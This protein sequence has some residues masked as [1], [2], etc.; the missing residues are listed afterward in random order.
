MKVHS[1]LL[2]L[3]AACG[4]SAATRAP[5][6]P[7]ST[8]IAPEAAATDT[9]DPACAAT[10]RQ[11]H[12]DAPD[13]DGYGAYCDE[14]CAP[15]TAPSAQCLS[16]CERSHQPGGRYDDNG[17]YVQ[18]DDERDDEV[19]F[20]DTAACTDEC[21]TVPTV[22]DEALAAC[23]AACTAGGGA[24]GSCGASCDPDPYDQCRYDPCD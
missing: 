6:A 5:A 16:S 14:L 3:V 8:D 19:Q 10:C 11:R 15:P 7:P 18:L 2:V 13:P 23:V 4:G 22:S 21:A 9:V 24:E 1:C 17:E 12:P 20:A